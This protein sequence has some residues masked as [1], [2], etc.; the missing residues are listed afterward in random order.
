MTTI[1]QEINDEP[2]G[3]EGPERKRLRRAE[4]QGSTSD[5]DAQIIQLLLQNETLNNQNSELKMRIEQL[6]EALRNRPAID[7]SNKLEE[8]DHWIKKLEKIHDE[9]IDLLKKSMSDLAENLKQEF[10]GKIDI[11]SQKFDGKIDTLSQKV[12]GKIDI[13]SQKIDKMEKSQQKK[14]DKMAGKVEDNAEDLQKLSRKISKIDKSMKAENE[15]TM[16]HMEEKFEKF[17]KRIF[18]KIDKSAEKEEENGQR[19]VIF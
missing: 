11:F 19:K 9:D 18:E 6:E 3:A 5:Q 12:D 1:K 15:K 8:M 16:K 17:Q 4:D 13:F 2:D 10:A 7:I 14:S